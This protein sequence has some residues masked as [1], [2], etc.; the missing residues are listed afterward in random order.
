MENKSCELCL[1]YQ[2][3][4][5]AEYKGFCMYHRVPCRS[6]NYCDNFSDGK[7]EE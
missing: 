3:D 2:I 7:D 6:Y 5:I 4:P 1:Y